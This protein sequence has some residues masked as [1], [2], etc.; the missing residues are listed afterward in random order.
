MKTKKEIDD[1]LMYIQDIEAILFR[2]IQFYDKT[3]EP[4]EKYE[5]F[6]AINSYQSKYST[7]CLC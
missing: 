3:K 4:K 6:D 5:L 7:Y 1:G 2:L